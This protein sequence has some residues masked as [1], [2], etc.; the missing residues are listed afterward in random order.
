MKFKTLNTK[1]RKEYTYTLD[2]VKEYFNCDTWGDD[3]ILKSYY[4]EYYNSLDTAEEKEDCKNFWLE[5]EVYENEI[6]YYKDMI[7][8]ITWTSPR[9]V[10][11]EFKVIEVIK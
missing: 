9:G 2:E 5:R 4:D 11:P 6:E 1:N 10:E 8:Y 7:E 3:H